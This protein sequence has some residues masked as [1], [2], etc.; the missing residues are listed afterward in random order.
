MLSGEISILILVVFSLNPSLFWKLKDQ[1]K[2]KKNA[3]LSWKSQIHV[4]ILRHRTWHINKVSY[5]MIIHFTGFLYIIKYFIIVLET[6]KYSKTEESAYHDFCH[7]YLEGETEK[8]ERSSKSLQGDTNF[9]SKE[10]LCKLKAKGA[11]KSE[12]GLCFAS[13]RNFVIVIV[14]LLIISAV[15][16][17]FQLSF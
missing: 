11:N 15:F 14:T 4:K 8:D 7:I 3:I 6:E 10:R 16:T 2:L 5:T 9:V 12:I 1:E 17:Y 13:H